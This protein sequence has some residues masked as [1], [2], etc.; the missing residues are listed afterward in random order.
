VSSDGSAFRRQQLLTQYHI[1]EDQFESPLHV[2]FPLCDWTQFIVI[3]SVCSSAYSLNHM[4]KLK[5]SYCAIIRGQTVYCVVLIL[6]IVS[7]S[8]S[9]IA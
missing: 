8:D 5:F 2:A 6:L 9:S 1:P 7:G 4:K 3:C